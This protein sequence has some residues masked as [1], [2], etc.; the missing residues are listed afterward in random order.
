MKN[1]RLGTIGWSYS[2]W[3]GSFYPNKTA[4]KDFLT[5]YAKQFNTVEVDSTFY[6]IPTLQ[7]VENWHK[8]T[9][10]GFMFSLKFPQ[11]ITHIKMLRDCPPQ[12]DAFLNRVAV[13][14]EKLGPLL[15]QFPPNFTAEHFSDLAAYLQNLPKHHRYV[16]EVRN[17]TWLTQEFYSLLRDN[18]VVLAWA[19]SSLIAGIDE[20]TGCFLY[21]RWEGDRK[22]VNGTLGKVEADKTADYALWAEK[23]KP[24]LEKTEVFGYFAKYYSGYPPH[25]IQSLSSFLV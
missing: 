19:D 15:L 22:A 20:V 17:K 4:P 18:G 14:G 5:H 21:V 2:F 16:V 6:R 11:L 24:Y 25:D 9:P 7:T 3:R 1:L 13:L 10:E 12:T 23:L 8:Q